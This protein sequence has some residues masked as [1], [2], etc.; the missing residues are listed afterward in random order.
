MSVQSWFCWPGSADATRPPEV[1]AMTTAT[2]GMRYRAVISS[3]SERWWDILA[4]VVSVFINMC[5]REGALNFLIARPGRLAVCTYTINVK[6][7]QVVRASTLSTHHSTHASIAMPFPHAGTHTSTVILMSVARPTG[8]VAT[9][10]LWW[11]WLRTAGKISGYM[12]YR[13]NEM[14]ENVRKR[15]R[16]RTKKMIEI[17]SCQCAEYGSGIW[18]TMIEVTPVLIVMMNHLSKISHTSYQTTSSGCGQGLTRA[19]SSV[20][21]CEIHGLLGHSLEW[22][23]VWVRRLRLCLRRRGLWWTAGPRSRYSAALVVELAT[24]FADLWRGRSDLL[25]GNE[26]GTRH[27]S[28]RRPLNFP[29]WYNVC[30]IFRCEEVKPAACGRWQVGR[31]PPSLSCW[32]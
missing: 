10:R 18:C 1:A 16:L 3:R 4:G 14:R 28:C 12:V 15:T 7:K 32:L 25:C 17:M 26:L 27:F 6:W 31:V 24:A 20:W 21:S 22:P 19:W 30:R 5:E 23:L 2:I 13:R 11:G 29:W 9:K 8:Q